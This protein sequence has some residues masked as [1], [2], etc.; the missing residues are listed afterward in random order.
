M[1]F[2]KERRLSK[3]TNMLACFA[4]KVSYKIQTLKKSLRMCYVYIGR[5][6]KKQ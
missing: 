2:C 1:V 4:S 3:D 6:T 5:N